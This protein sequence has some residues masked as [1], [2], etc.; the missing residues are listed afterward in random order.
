MHTRIPRK[1]YFRSNSI[2]VELL[3]H[4]FFMKFFSVKLFGEYILHIIG[5]QKIKFKKIEFSDRVS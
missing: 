5:Y 3:C 2:W 1:L 4:N